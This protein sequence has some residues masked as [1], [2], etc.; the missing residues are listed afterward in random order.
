MSLIR[1]YRHIVGIGNYDN[2]AQR[3]QMTTTLG[4]AVVRSC[5]LLGR[6]RVFE[7]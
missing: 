5:V 2:A 4:G 3:W 6:D 7:V 1:C